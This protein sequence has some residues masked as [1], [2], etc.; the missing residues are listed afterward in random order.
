MSQQLAGYMVEREQL[1]T[2]VQTKH[3]EAVTFHAEAVRLTAL[4]QEGAAV[5]TA[6]ASDDSELSKLRQDFHDRKQ[7]VRTVA[8]EL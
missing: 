2:A 3:Q 6:A 1:M 4:L 7:Q 8:I 5:Q